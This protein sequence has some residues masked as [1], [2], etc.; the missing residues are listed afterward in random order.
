MC[1]PRIRAFVPGVLTTG[2]D[3]SSGIGAAGCRQRSGGSCFSSVLILPIR[4]L[5]I[6]PNLSLPARKLL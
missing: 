3:R 4:R 6:S 5:P 2:S 1:A